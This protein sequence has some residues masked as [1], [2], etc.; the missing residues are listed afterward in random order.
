MNGSKSKCE[1][2]NGSGEIA[3]SIYFPC[4]YV[5]PGPV[6]DYATG[7]VASRCDECLGRAL[8][9]IALLD[10][11]DGHELTRD[12]AL[13]AIAI[14]TKALGKHPSEIF[15]ERAKLGSNKSSD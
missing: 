10:E 11:A 15:A 12:H 7:V 9:D 2:C 5:G 3:V 8:E 4:G 1:R 13:E 6:P 14:A